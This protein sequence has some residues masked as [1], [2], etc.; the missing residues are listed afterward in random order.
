MDIIALINNFG[1][2]VACTI[3]LFVLYN[4][5]ITSFKESIDNNTKMTEQVYELIK[6]LINKRE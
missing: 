1:F 2:P 5:T 3:V 6:D 4:R